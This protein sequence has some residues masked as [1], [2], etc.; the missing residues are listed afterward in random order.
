LASSLRP[1]PRQIANSA[2]RNKIQ[3]ASQ[4]AQGFMFGNKKLNWLLSAL[5]E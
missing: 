4:T 2:T 1:A 3:L 5:V